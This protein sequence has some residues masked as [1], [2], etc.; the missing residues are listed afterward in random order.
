[1]AWIA[2]HPKFMNED[3]T[4]DKNAQVPESCIQSAEFIIQSCYNRNPPEWSPEEDAEPYVYMHFGSGDS[5]NITITQNIQ[6]MDFSDRTDFN[7]DKYQPTIGEGVAFINAS[8]KD[9]NSRSYNMHFMAILVV[10]GTK[11]A[12]RVTGYIIS[13]VN[14]LDGKKIQLVSLS[15]ENTKF[16][17]E[18]NPWPDF[19][20]KYGMGSGVTYRLAL[21]S[22]NPTR[23][24]V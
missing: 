18:A 8:N 11:R 17:K 5:V 10:Q 20:R 19:V 14:E 6:N 24:I 15:K 21:L 4:I 16:L 9:A 22:T 1:M 12:N 7:F 3:G 2:L 13:D 23:P